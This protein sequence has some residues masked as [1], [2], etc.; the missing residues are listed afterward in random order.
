MLFEQTHS[1]LTELSTLLDASAALA[2]TRDL[3]SIL[4]QITRRLREALGVGR[5]VVA[6][7]DQRLSQMSMVASVVDAAWDRESAPRL[8]LVAGSP[9]RAALT[10]ANSVSLG[11][12][13][14]EWPD[15]YE[16]L[17]RGARYV[18]NVPLRGGD[19]IEGVISIYG[20]YAM[21]PAQAAAVEKAAAGW[22]D[23]AD[24][25][26]DDL[27]ILCHRSLQAAN[28]LWCAVYQY[29]A[30]TSA[31]YLRRETGVASWEEHAA[32]LINL[33]DFLTLKETIISGEARTVSRAAVTSK[34]EEL[35]FDQL[36]V[37]TALMVQ[38]SMQDQPAGLVQA[39][40]TTSSSFDDSAFSLVEGIANVISSA[41]KS[42][43]LYSSVEKRAEALEA[44]YREIEEADRLKDEL[45]QNL[46][47]ELGTPLTH[48]LGYLSLLEEGAF[49]PLQLEQKNTIHMIVEKAGRMA[50]LVKHMVAMHS[51]DVHHLSLKATR[52][53]QL[54]ALAVRSM[55][56][57]ARAAGI[58]IVANFP[59]N[60]PLVRVDQVA[61]S[62]VFEALLDNAIKFS[63]GGR[64]V[65]ITIR[66]FQGPT[67]QVTIRDQGIGIPAQEYDKVFKQFYQVDQGTT[68]KFGGMGLGLAIVRK[69]IQA[70]SGRVWIESEVDKGTTIHFTVPKLDLS[71]STGATGR[72]AK[73]T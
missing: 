34:M 31:L 73:T 44:A 14:T 61:M 55:T 10:Q 52:L 2:S 38:L 22:H 7:V 30:A 1:R 8:A 11:S 64:R 54:A 26:W 49:G 6:T 15:Y 40:A 42:A 47:H 33:A 16:L 57:R 21:K 70:H 43:A 45:I 20:Q 65:E 51:G 12:I 66:D 60:L 25:P 27:T 59:A 72:L 58:E 9:K 28:A 13:N 71:A 50:E 17:M 53:D 56:A 24:D 5:V 68:R 46:S 35:Y 3:R 37:S 62:E 32:P 67:L 23:A 18:L 63:R 19:K 29:D 36:G 48:V 41:L 39:L 4:E 69:I